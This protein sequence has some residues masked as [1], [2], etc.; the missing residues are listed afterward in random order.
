M[1]VKIRGTT[2]KLDGWDYRIKFDMPPVYFDNTNYNICVRSLFMDLS[3]KDNVPTS[4]HWSLKTTMV[5]RCN[6]NPRQ[7]IASFVSELSKESGYKFVYY[8]P[9]IKQEYKIQLSSLHGSEF[10][11]SSLRKD[12]QLEIEFVE[13]LLEFSRYARI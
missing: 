6:V 1:L 3:F 4:Q 11:L 13:I 5:D 12:A 2:E 9:R 7:E 10:I 8:E